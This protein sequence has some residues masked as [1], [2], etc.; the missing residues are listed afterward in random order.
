VL[1]PVLPN[2]DAIIAIVLSIVAFVVNAESVYTLAST[3]GAAGRDGDAALR[4][5]GGSGVVWAELKACTP[6]SLSPS[7][8]VTGLFGPR[9]K[10]SPAGSANHAPT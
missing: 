8:G 10:S 9:Q 4:H 5:G 7:N 1:V 3:S 2:N 6:A